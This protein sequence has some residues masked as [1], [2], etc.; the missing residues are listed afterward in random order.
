M[1][2]GFVRM[3]PPSSVRPKARPTEAQRARAKAKAKERATGVLQI[4]DDEEMQIGSTTAG[5]I[6]QWAEDNV[7]MKELLQAEGLRLQMEPLLRQ[8]LPNA[9]PGA[10]VNAYDWVDCDLHRAMLLEC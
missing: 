1:Y 3:P 8:G 10:E 9:V 7:Q 5:Q 4:S 2:R 6:A